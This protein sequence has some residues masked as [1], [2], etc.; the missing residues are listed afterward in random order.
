MEF[1]F[2]CNDWLWVDREKVSSKIYI[3]ENDNLLCERCARK[4][5]NYID[6]SEYEFL[7]ASSYNN[8]QVMCDCCGYWK[9]GDDVMVACFRDCADY[10][11]QCFYEEYDIDSVQ[12][13]SSFT[14]IEDGKE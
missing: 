2:V 3:D 7:T 6:P 10:C 13:L 1:C 5:Y 12:P 11:E 8:G 9:V 14:S 4:E